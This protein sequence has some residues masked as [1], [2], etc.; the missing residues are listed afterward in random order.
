MAVSLQ[1]E[2]VTPERQLISRE[3][4]SVVVPGQDGD[5]GVLPGH[6][7]FLSLVRAGVVTIDEDEHFAVTGGYAEAVPE[8]VTLLV[9]LAEPG[10]G[11]DRGE[12]EENHRQAQEAFAA[13]SPDD[14]DYENRKADLGFAKARLDAS[15]KP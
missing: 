15:P 2:L 13:L 4:T 12:A 7:P 3:V 10:E 8:R 6:A 11:I 5:F 1:L 9:D 14:P